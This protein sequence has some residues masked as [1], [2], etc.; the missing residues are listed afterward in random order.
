MQFDIGILYVVIGISTH[1]PRTRA[2][3][4]TKILRKGM[5]ITTAYVRQAIITGVRQKPPLPTARSPRRSLISRPK[6]LED[7]PDHHE[8]IQIRHTKK[9]AFLLIFKF[10]IRP[11]LKLTPLITWN[12]TDFTILIFYI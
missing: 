3:Y 10:F 1:Q 12:I 5:H 9:C 4:H 8:E 2:S 6:N 7:H 11:L